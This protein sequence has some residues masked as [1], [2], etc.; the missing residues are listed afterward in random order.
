MA[1]GRPR[2][3]VLEPKIHRFSQ[4]AAIVLSLCI[5]DA[6]CCHNTKSRAK[7]YNNR[8]QNA[9]AATRG[10]FITLGHVASAR[11]IQAAM[12]QSAAWPALHKLIKHVQVTWAST[13]IVMDGIRCGKVKA[14]HPVPASTA[15]G[16]FEITL[17]LLCR[18]NVYSIGQ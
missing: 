17:R 5:A 15:R 18:T 12:L 6:N 7:A 9:A 2:G 13:R 16:I 11:R 1:T 3:Q 4:E 14:R 8:R 10:A